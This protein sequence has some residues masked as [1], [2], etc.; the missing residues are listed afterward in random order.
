MARVLPLAILLS[1]KT[2]FRALPPTGL[3]SLVTSEFTTNLFQA[4]FQ[5][6]VGDEQ[7]INRHQIGPI[8]G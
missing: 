7:G 6:T 2:S 8:D 1:G 4:V 3:S 5:V